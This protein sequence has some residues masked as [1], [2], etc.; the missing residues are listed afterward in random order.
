[1]LRIVG[2]G[3]LRLRS[4]HLIRDRRELRDGG[5]IVVVIVREEHHVVAA[6][7]D[8]GGIDHHLL[9]VAGDGT[10]NLLLHAGGQR[11]TGG[12]ERGVIGRLHLRLRRHDRG[13]GRH[14][15]GRG[16][17]LR[18]ALPVHNHREQQLRHA[19]VEG[20]LRRKDGGEHAALFRRGG[21]VLPGEAARN[22]VAVDVLHGAG[23]GGVRK[24]L[25]AGDLR[26]GNIKFRAVYQR[27]E[28][29]RKGLL[30]GGALRLHIFESLI[31]LQRGDQDVAV[32]G[33]LDRAAQL[34]ARLAAGEAVCGKEPG[35]LRHAQLGGVVI[36][37]DLAQRRT[38]GGMRLHEIVGVE[39]AVDVVDVER[40]AAEIVGKPIPIDLIGHL[41][42]RAGHVR[43]L[44]QQVDQIAGPAAEIGIGTRGALGIA[45]APIVG[46]VHRAEHMQHIDLIP[47]GNVHHIFAGF[48]IG[49]DG[50][51]IGAVGG[52]L[53][54][55]IGGERLIFLAG[56]TCPMAGGILRLGGSNIVEHQLEG[57][58]LH[59]RICRRVRVRVPL[60]HG[61]IFDKGVKPRRVRLV[62]GNRRVHRSQQAQSQAQHQNERQPLLHRFLLH[63]SDPFFRRK[64]NFP[65]IYT[66]F[67]SDAQLRN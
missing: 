34:V 50:L 25:S 7:V 13:R 53:L 54:G 17:G 66:V 11:R 55:D 45:A 51:H 20:V 27:E 10:L 24:G 12:I 31:A 32:I 15:G 46:D 1:M 29:V 3:V 38:V 16:R 22:V 23:N 35:A 41:L 56:Q 26:S 64:T 5:G 4:G 18:N 59:V 60:Q 21:S 40:T 14:D 19:I 49:L 43:G 42:S 36:A 44:C 48:S 28:V 9:I 62:R 6:D 8:G 65:S 37:H 67:S 57:V 47:V 63:V 2:V 39:I 33:A 58:A 30:A 61:E 52:V